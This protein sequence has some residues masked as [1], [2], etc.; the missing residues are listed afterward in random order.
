MALAS[1]HPSL[2]QTAPCHF[3]VPRVDASRMTGVKET[4]YQLSSFVLQSVCHT[5]G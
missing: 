3:I 4:I 1:I 2:G 5:D